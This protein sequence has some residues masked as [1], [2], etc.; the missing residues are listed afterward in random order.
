MCED[1][2]GFLDGHDGV[3]E[4]PR[5]GRLRSHFVESLGGG[6][7]TEADSSFLLRLCPIEEDSKGLGRRR[8]VKVHQVHSV[9][10]RCGFSLSQSKSYIALCNRH[11]TKRQEVEELKETVAVPEGC[12]MGA[13]SRRVRLI[14]KAKVAAVDRGRPC[15]RGDFSKLRERIWKSQ[16]TRT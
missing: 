13:S 15:N 11:G 3:L 2:G 4:S 12:Q 5:S 16:K 10:S 6:M 7:A 9:E 14:D 1:H 8:H